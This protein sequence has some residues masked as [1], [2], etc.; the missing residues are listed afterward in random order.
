[1]GRNRAKASTYKQDKA[2]A[3]Q[4]KAAEVAEAKAASKGKGS[5]PTGGKDEPKKRTRTF[6][7]FGCGKP[8][9][10]YDELLKEHAPKCIAKDKVCT[11]CK[12]KGAV[13]THCPCKGQGKPA[14]RVQTVRAPRNYRARVPFDNC[15]T[16]N[17]PM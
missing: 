9:T 2:E 5:N 6:K 4:R 16:P 3:Q 14:S 17:S 7:C 12:K 13:P 8:F 1:M 11:G 15:P 10:S